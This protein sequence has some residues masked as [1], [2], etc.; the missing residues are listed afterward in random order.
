VLCLRAH[1]ALYK[2]TAGTYC[3]ILDV[4]E[5]FRHR[6]IVKLITQKYK[7]QQKSFIKFRPVANFIKL[8]WYHLRCYRRN[9]LSI[10]SGYAARGVNYT[11]KVL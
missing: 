11:K 6:P 9:V 10:D 5:S 4:G 1:Y 7:S 2:G 8:F 3:Q